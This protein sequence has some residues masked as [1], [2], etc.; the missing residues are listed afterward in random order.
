ML[1]GRL[2]AI[3]AAAGVAIAAIVALRRLRQRR[4]LLEAWERDGYVI[5]KGLLSA[6]ECARLEEAVTADGGIEQ[7]ALGKDDG[8]GRKTRMALWN[9]PGNDVTGMVARIPRVRR[10]ME[11]LV[12]GGFMWHQDYGYWVNN[13]CPFPRMG[14]CFSPID[15]MDAENAGLKVI[16]GS[17][18]MGLMQ[19]GMTGAQAEVRPARLDGRLTQQLFLCGAAQPS[20]DLQPVRCIP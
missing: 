8:M 16:R 11:T 2:A 17:H 15:K 9:H 13:G 6:A 10:T 4:K 20:A 3:G 1:S 12:G 14:T 18:A 7:H 5:I 19:H